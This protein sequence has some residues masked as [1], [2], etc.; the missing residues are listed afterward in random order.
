M[1]FTKMLNFLGEWIS[2][3][4]MLLFEP[5]RFIPVAKSPIQGAALTAT[6]RK[7]V[8]FSASAVLVATVIVQIADQ[9]DLYARLTQ[10]APLALLTIGAWLI[11][12]IILSGIL[13]ALDG[14]QPPITNIVFGIRML[15]TFYVFSVVVG[16]I[17]FLALRNRWPVSD[18]WSLNDQ[19]DVFAKAELLTNFA[20]CA[21]YTPFVFGRAN[22][23]SRTKLF[24]FSVF[25]ILLYALK[26]L[27]NY[28]VT[29]FNHFPCCGK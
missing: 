1:S 26:T 22:N 7:H 27:V 11:W 18:Q 3:S 23:L 2:T 16:T 29:V 19:W 17:A 5:A 10:S 13:R 8:G 9:H 20:L 4:I 6:T 12:S 21:F 15:A 28:T 25:A 14:I 24:V